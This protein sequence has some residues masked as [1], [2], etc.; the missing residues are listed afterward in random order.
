MT[1]TFCGR[2]VIIDDFQ[3]REIIDINVGWFSLFFTKLFQYTS[4]I[5]SKLYGSNCS[6]KFGFSRTTSSQSLSLQSINDSTPTIS[7]NDTSGRS[8]SSEV[9]PK[10][11]I[12][13]DLKNRTVDI[14]REYIIGICKFRI[15]D[16]VSKVVKVE[17][18]RSVESNAP[19][20]CTSKILGHTTQKFVMKYRWFWRE[21][22]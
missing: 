10:G 4:K 11:S 1:S 19:S 16:W 3:G 12:S 20:D 6:N 17:R 8:S 13:K 22:W 5:S 14:D 21:L 7:E 9:I 15:R 2:A 18:R